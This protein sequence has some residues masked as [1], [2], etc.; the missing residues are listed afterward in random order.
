[1]FN[2]VDSKFYGRFFKTNFIDAIKSSIDE[3]YEENKD[4]RKTVNII[5]DKMSK[6]INLENESFRVTRKA[7]ARLRDLDNCN[8]MNFKT[9]IDFGAGSGS[10]TKE[11]HKLVPNRTGYAIDIETWSNKKNLSD[12]V[13]IN[14]LTPILLNPNEK[15]LLDCIP[16]HSIDVIFIDY[17]IHHIQDTDQLY[18]V[19]HNKLKYNGVVIVKEHDIDNDKKKD[20]II[21][22]HMFYSAIEN[23][24]VPL[25]ENYKSM[26]EFRDEWNNF[27]FI[28]KLIGRNDNFTAF[29]Y[30]KSV[31]F[32]SSY[33]EKPFA[34]DIALDGYDKTLS[35]FLDKNNIEYTTNI[36]YDSIA[37]VS[38][39]LGIAS[40]ELSCKPTLVKNDSY[41]ETIMDNGLFIYTRI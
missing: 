36:Q 33:I 11:F 27:A 13:N 20:A 38:H 32:L 28:V 41:S 22:E 7:K 34:I 37:F 40:K 16:N 10:I 1:M 15:L 9:Y 26:K 21:L 23:S 4:E 39:F 14:G 17:V 19:I 12:I 6:H 24:D 2:S 5:I 25:Y 35:T 3:I 31:I 30:P 29:L 18:R 8:M